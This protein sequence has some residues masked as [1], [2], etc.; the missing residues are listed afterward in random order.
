MSDELNKKVIDIF[1]KH[2][3]KTNPSLKNDFGY[4]C[5]VFDKDKNGL[6][7]NSDHLIEYAK[8]CS[9][10][11]RIMKE[12]NGETVLFNYNVP[13]ENFLDFIN[14]VQ[15]NQIQGTI[16]EIDKYFPEDLA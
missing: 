6:K 16:I 4:C 1:S 11:V 5:V 8:S 10:V 3:N 15:T 14:K 2:K 7:F 9:Y 12:H 13:S